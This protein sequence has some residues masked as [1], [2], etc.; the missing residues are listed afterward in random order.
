MLVKNLSLTHS[1]KQKQETRS[2]SEG[3]IYNLTRGVITFKL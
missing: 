3:F 1:F 2:N